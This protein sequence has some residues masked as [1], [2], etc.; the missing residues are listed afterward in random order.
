MTA[1]HGLELAC[2][3]GIAGMLNPL[4]VAVFFAYCIAV[5]ISGSQVEE[6]IWEAMYWP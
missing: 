2:L 6:E 1:D 4:L 3:L 5:S